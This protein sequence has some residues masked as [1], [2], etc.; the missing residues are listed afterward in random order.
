MPI[1][2]PYFIYLFIHSFIHACIH[3]FIY[4]LGIER[5]EVSSLFCGS[6]EQNLICPVIGSG[7]AKRKACNIHSAW[8]D[9]A[10]ME[11][12]LRWQLRQFLI[13]RGPVSEAATWASDFPVSTSL[14]A[15]GSPSLRSSTGSVVSLA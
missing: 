2:Q 14:G 15:S 6:I 3:S 12:V 5:V 1:V 8:A 9:C 13:Y 10:S 4:F 7:G 11:L